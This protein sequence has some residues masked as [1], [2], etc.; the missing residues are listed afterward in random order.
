M[1]PRYQAKIHP[2]KG[3]ALT[4]WQYIRI[5]NTDQGKYSLQLITIMI[6]IIAVN[7]Y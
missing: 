2:P 6:N 7:S 4:C 5:A 1:T 3:I